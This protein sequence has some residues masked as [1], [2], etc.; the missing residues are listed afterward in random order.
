MSQPAISPEFRAAGTDLSERRRSGVSKGPLID[1]AG[2]PDITGIVWGADGATRIGALTTIAEIAADA[3][4]A[5]PPVR[6]GNANG[7]EL[8]VRR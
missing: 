8:P 7:R 6:P 3:R 5:Q 4:I 2:T 1:I